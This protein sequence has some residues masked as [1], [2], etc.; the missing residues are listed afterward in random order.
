MNRVE[1]TY[2]RIFA[3]GQFLIYYHCAVD[4][5]NNGLGVHDVALELR[6]D[7]VCVGDDGLRV[8]DITADVRNDI[9]GV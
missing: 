2:R 7:D 4:I 8:C 9:L 3:L 6:N 1:Y 5:R